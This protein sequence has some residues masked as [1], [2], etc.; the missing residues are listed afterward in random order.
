MLTCDTCQHQSLASCV[1]HLVTQFVRSITQSESVTTRVT[2]SLFAFPE[3]VTPGIECRVRNAASFH[4]SNETAKRVWS[5]EYSQESQGND[6]TVI[7]NKKQ[8]S[9]SLHILEWGTSCLNCRPQYIARPRCVRL[10]SALVCQ[11][12]GN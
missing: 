9:N 8:G 7:G 12:F 1:H 11:G 3:S 4:V 6:C 5:V 2:T 10:N